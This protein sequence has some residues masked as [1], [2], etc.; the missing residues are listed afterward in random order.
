MAGLQQALPVAG[1]L[2]LLCVDG[3]VAEETW[4]MALECANPIANDSHYS[5]VQP[6][7]CLLCTCNLVRNAPNL[8]VSHNRT[9]IG[10][11]L[12]QQRPAVFAFVQGLQLW[13]HKQ[14]ARPQIPSYHTTPCHIHACKSVQCR[15]HFSN[16]HAASARKSV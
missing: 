13:W 4:H 12:C 11:H 3:L 8:P 6:P 5:I 1:Q 7:S 15:L 14:C 10:L 16:H 9:D 2:C